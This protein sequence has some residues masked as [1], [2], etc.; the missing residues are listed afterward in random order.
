[1]TL[2]TETMVVDGRERPARALLRPFLA[3]GS[4]LAMVG[5]L[6]LAAT[7][8]VALRTSPGLS[9]DLRLLNAVSS[10][11]LA[12]YPLHS[13]LRGATRWSIL[14]L[15][16]ACG[17]LALLRPRLGLWLGAVIV[18]GGA[19][20]SAQVLQHDV[21]TRPVGDPGANGLPSQHM[22]VALSVGLAAVLVAPAAWRSIVVIGVSA[23]AT[24]AGV[25]LV[26]GRWHRPSDVIA[27]VFL[28]LV[29]AAV[30]LVAAALVRHRPAAP[31]R[32]TLAVLAALIGAW[33]ISM[34]LAWWGARP[35]AD[36]PDLALPIISLGSIGLVC[37]LCVAA[38]AHLAD[39]HL[40]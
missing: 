30:G 4:V 34:L 13:D 35:P 27:A 8:Y 6:G 22:T 14:A 37:T 1:L 11:S 21:F 3:A 40:G 5:L 9:L 16:L 12:Q 25:A 32:S 26:L 31:S 24:L 17:L 39:R 38:I 20:L 33:T 23:A 19:T 10:T 18:I 2:V 29:W 36:L 7:S 15:A 28:C